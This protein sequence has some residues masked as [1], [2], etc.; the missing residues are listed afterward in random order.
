[1][2][3]LPHHRSFGALIVGFDDRRT[4]SGL[5]GHHFR[6]LHG[7]DPAERT[8]LGKGLPHADHAGA[9]AGGVDDPVGQRPV[10]LLGQLVAHGLFA[11]DAIRLLEGGDVVPAQRFP[12]L[13]RDASGVGNQ[14]VHQ[15]DVGAVEFTL[16][17]E[18]RLHVLG[19]EHPGGDPCPRGV[20]GHGV[21]GVA[22]RRH[23]QHGGAEMVRTGDGG[24]QSTRLE[25]IGRVEGL[26]LDVQMRQAEL[27]AEALR[28][29][30]WR[31]PFAERNRALALEQRHQ[32]AIS[33]HR[34][35]ASG[36]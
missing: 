22:G 14:S 36:Q 3:V 11:F 10:E 27:G 16:T 31:P 4:S 13:R 28:V 5:H 23:R 21:T 17:N 29:G 12:G 19:H 20:G 1:M 7:I 2:C 33:P 26:V 15:R 32:F 8:H 34:G 30:Q 35:F 6:A 25:G 9:A 18:R 24:R